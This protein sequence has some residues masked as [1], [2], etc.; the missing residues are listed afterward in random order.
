MVGTVCLYFYKANKDSLYVPS[1]H[2]DA[3][4][5]ILELS[6]K[7]KEDLHKDCLH[8]STKY[9]PVAAFLNELLVYVD[10]H[11]EAVS[12]E[13]VNYRTL[14]WKCLKPH[15]GGYGD[16]I[17]GMAHSFLMAV[18]SE[19]ALLIKPMSVYRDKYD[20]GPDVLVPKAVDWRALLAKEPFSPPQQVFI[21]NGP[22]HPS[23]GAC[24]AIFSTDPTYQH[25]L[26]TTQH[27]QRS[28]LLNTT[29]RTDNRLLQQFRTLPITDDDLYEFLA[30]ILSYLLFQYSKT[31]RNKEMRLKKSWGI[32]HSPYI[33]VH[34]RTGMF[35]NG[36][37]EIINRAQTKS[38]L[39]KSQIVCAIE[40][41]KSV[42][43]KGPVV[44]VSDSKECKDW[45]TEA[46]PKVVH[47][48]DLAPLHSAKSRPNATNIKV[49]AVD[50]ET[51]FE[52]IVLNAA[53][54]A[55][56]SHADVLVQESSGF[57]R[58]AKWI[59]GIPSTRV[60]CCFSKCS[61]YHVIYQTRI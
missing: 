58:A 38:R 46:F 61:N 40:K 59:G 11:K 37:L 47:T 39:W 51:Y 57:S 7:Y 19:R 56:L 13:G 5:E 60:F 30:T 34:V 42:G 23:A 48:T 4:L 25:V 9:R 31:V 21:D 15:C 33:G 18:M 20:P 16:Q 8:F 12:R 50:R 55:L 53:E 3:C 32:P 36:P 10:W 2:I 17:R 6:G 26:Y 52:E 1:V 22:L 29:A 41:A 14:T 49:V 27:W 54:M 35:L 24:G 43:L 45:L 28:C 44:V